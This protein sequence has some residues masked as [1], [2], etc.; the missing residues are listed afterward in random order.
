MNRRV[1]GIIALVTLLFILP[2]AVLPSSANSALTKWGG[3]DAHGVM[4]SGGQSPI[5]VEHETLTFNISTL[6]EQYEVGS[7]AIAMEESHVT[8][9]YT[10]Y[11]PSDMDITA[12][13]AFPIAV[14][15]S[16]DYD[17]SD[18]GFNIK[19]N[20][21]QIEK[22]VRHTLKTDSLDFDLDTDLSRLLEDYDTDEFLKPSTVVTKYEI[23]FSGI[24]MDTYENPYFSLYIEPEDYPNTKFYFDRTVYHHSTASGGFRIYGRVDNLVTTLTLYAIGEPIRSLP[25]IKYYENSTL[26]A[27][28]EGE[29]AGSAR[30]YSSETTNLEQF[31][32]RGYNETSGVSRMDW[33]NAAIA[34]M[35][36][37]FDDPVWF[38]S[39]LTNKFENKLLLWYEY[40]LH[41]GPKERI[42]NSVTAPMVAGI[43]T[44][45][46]PA[47]YDYT[48][49]LSPAVTWAEFG[50]LDIIINT[51]YYMTYSN[52]D[53]FEKTEDGYKLSLD[54][55][56]RYKGDISISIEDGIKR[57]PGKV[58]DLV[59]KLSE[60]ENPE[61]V[62]SGS[63]SGGLVAI[64]I[65]LGIIFLPIVLVVWLVNWIVS[66][67]SGL[68]EK[69]K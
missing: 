40:D 53:G 27:K 12:S 45:Y 30:I 18:P 68:V 5:V 58:I 67:V 9:E 60:S 26:L 52:I 55:L 57:E 35:K 59:F 37:K 16:S 66:G 46:S 21:E 29:I 3:E 2:M 25:E 10:F 20:G 47:V 23:K 36:F 38:L 6:P 51:P 62:K 19:V 69:F 42:V 32:Y 48:Y 63:M 28:N 61:N 50:S 24:D 41:F 14:L 17:E 39:A 7:D 22:R 33:Y 65:V 8:A 31:I 64:L 13:L 56:P 43:D 4:A 44:S 54:G 34:L 1:R 15:N 49:L 11:N